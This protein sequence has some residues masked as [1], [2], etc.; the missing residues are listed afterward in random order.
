MLKYSKILYYILADDL[1]YGDIDYNYQKIIKTHNIEKMIKE[2]IINSQHYAGSTVCAPSRCSILK[3][4][5][6]E[7][8]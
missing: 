5:H 4:S 8:Y 6:T 1:G 3:N 2:G 7:H